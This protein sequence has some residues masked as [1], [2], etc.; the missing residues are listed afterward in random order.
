MEPFEVI[1]DDELFR[2]SERRQPSGALSYDFSWLN[3][4]ADGTYG[5]NASQFIASSTDAP[6]TSVPSITRD[7]LV[8]EVRGFVKSVYELGGIGEDFPDHVSAS[9][10]RR[11][12]R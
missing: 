1:V 3:G 12:A 2:I 4:P 11:N 7:E 6:L 9:S 5:F 8:A 10:R